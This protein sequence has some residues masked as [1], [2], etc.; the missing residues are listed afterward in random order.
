[1]EV[2][3]SVAKACTCDSGADQSSVTCPDGTILISGGCGNKLGTGRISEDYP[4]SATR[5]YCDWADGPNN[6]YAFALCCRINTTY[7]LP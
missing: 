5:W 3:D 4:T 7:T 2:L 6:E 1:M